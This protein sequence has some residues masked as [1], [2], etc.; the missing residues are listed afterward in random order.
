VFLDGTIVKVGLSAIRASLH[1]GLSDRQWVVDAYLL[2]LSSLLLIDRLLDD[3]YGRR[4]VFAISVAAL[5][6][7]RKHSVDY[8]PSSGCTRKSHGRY[9]NG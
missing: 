7:Q 2:M 1:G 3:L 8:R 6:Q 5:W 9:L 4:R